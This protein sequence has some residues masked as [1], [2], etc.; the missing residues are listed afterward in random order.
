MSSTSL[1]SAM[2]SGISGRSPFIIL[3][4]TALSFFILPYGGFPV[5]IYDQCDIQFGDYEGSDWA[6]F[7]HRHPKRKYI[8]CFRIGWIVLVI[9]RRVQDLWRSPPCW[10]CYLVCGEFTMVDNE[11]KTKISN[12]RIFSFINQDIGLIII[13]GIYVS[14]FSFSPTARKS[15]WMTPMEW[16]YSRPQAIPRT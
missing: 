10:T 14:R 8:T 2:L 5:R 6:Y 1:N 13:N 4:I 9:T 12:H 16:R 11:S 3:N 7:N 15:P